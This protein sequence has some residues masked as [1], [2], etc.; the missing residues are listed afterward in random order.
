MG[1]YLLGGFRLGAETEKYLA[2]IKWK[3]VRLIV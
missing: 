2:A 3:T 1:T